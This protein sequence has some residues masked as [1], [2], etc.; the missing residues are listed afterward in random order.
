MYKGFLRAVVLGFLLDIGCSTNLKST[1]FAEKMRGN[2][3]E[4]TGQMDAIISCFRVGV[5]KEALEGVRDAKLT[6]DDGKYEY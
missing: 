4:K 3:A 5:Q 2:I 1:A 6:L